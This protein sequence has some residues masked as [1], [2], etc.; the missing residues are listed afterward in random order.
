MDRTGTWNAIHGQR[1]ALAVDL[2]DL[3]E[4]QW[5]T[6][7]LCDG[8]SVEETLAHLAAGALK[9]RFRWITSVIRARFDFRQTQPPT[10]QRTPR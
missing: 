8:W 7:S 4:R 2:A 9:T 3:D 6:Q 5:V 1:A 10:P